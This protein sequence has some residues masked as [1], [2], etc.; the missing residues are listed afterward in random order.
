MMKRVFAWIL[1]L[2]GAL[3][4]WS[5]AKE[6]DMDGRGGAPGEIRL[7]SI[8]RQML[9]RAD[10]GEYHFPEGTKYTL[11]SVNHAADAASY[12]WASF[13]PGFVSRPQEG[14]E[15]VVSGRH[16][17]GYSPSALVSAGDELD[18][19]ALTFNSTDEAP[20]LD[21]APADGVNPTITLSR[22]DGSARRRLPDL[23][24]GS[25]RDGWTP[26]EGEVILPFEHQLAGIRFLV[27]KQDESDLPAA[28]RIFEGVKLNQV[29]LYNTAEEATM[30][31]VTGELT[32]QPRTVD[33]RDTCVVF[34][35]DMPGHT[36]YGEP[37]TVLTTP[38][39][40]N[41][42]VL[43][44]P[45]DDGDPTNNQLGS[46]GFYWFSNMA[47]PDKYHA[48]HDESG[49]CE[50]LFVVLRLTG[51]DPSLAGTQVGSGQTVTADGTLRARC[52]LREYDKDGNDIGPL[53]LLAN[54]KYVFSIVLTHDDIRLV[55]VTP[56][57][58]E[59]EDVDLSTTTTTTSPD[60]DRV[61]VLGQPVVVGNVVWMDRNMGATSA[62]CA[63]DFW[64]TLGPYYEYGRNIPFYIDTDVVSSSALYDKFYDSDPNP[65]ASYWPNM[66]TPATSA[67]EPVTWRW[68]CIY[69]YNEK[70]ERVG[71]VRK[72]C[73]KELIDA[74]PSGTPVR[75]LMAI[76]PGDP[77]D[78]SF[79]AT[80][81]FDGAG[82]VWYS[83]AEG[84]AG[85]HAIDYETGEGEYFRK[86]W[87]TP[88]TQPV[89]KGWRLPTYEDACSLF[90]ELDW[91]EDKP[92]EDKIG[93]GKV[94]NVMHE[95][96]VLQDK[97]VTLSGI[98]DQFQYFHGSMFLDPSATPVEKDGEQYYLPVDKGPRV[99][100]YNDD[101]KYGLGRLVSWNGGVYRCIQAVTDPSV[102]HTPASAAFWDRLPDGFTG[103]DG[104]MLYVC[105]GLKFKGTSRAYRVR[106]E[107]HEADV[108]IGGAAVHGCRYIRFE[109]FPATAEDSFKKVTI[110]GKDYWNL[111]GFDWNHPSAVLDFPLQGD[112]GAPS[113]KGSIG[114]FGITLKMH[115]NRY[116]KPQPSVSTVATTIYTMKLSTASGVG[117]WTSTYQSTS[118]PIRLVRD[119]AATD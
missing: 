41:S 18:F 86:A 70:G 80:R 48:A 95:F 74:A 91:D 118:C 15:T 52:P 103:G 88:Q 20:A 111:N 102:A 93:W 83:N 97:S 75:S 87:A 76:D 26:D 16:S 17:I 46:H 6:Q 12:Q 56:Q 35:S 67:G 59:W 13:A 44:F 73:L 31:L 115:L 49:K 60:L 113:G 105:Y 68:N 94:Y 101:V 3:L 107:I 25:F 119:V 96:G 11:L 78:Y 34:T 10:A 104:S 7:T 90:P 19:F 71:T 28:R 21:A 27:S 98:V 42:E 82:G 92:E 54:H 89:P 79:F 39:V 5:C 47:D 114:E 84:T 33:N 106:M 108:N 64:H 100:A 110:D 99:E 22:N 58:Y 45:N 66:N 72:G 32:V 57:V 43:V 62:D 38:S 63:N 61:G 14:T 40:A 117:A 23:M 36:H 9:T 65:G 112:L 69:T 51:F 37:V 1:P 4:V 8:R 2:A 53:H 55:T 50:Q 24:A 30:D 109:T 81:R 116:Q 77:G 85:T 29:I